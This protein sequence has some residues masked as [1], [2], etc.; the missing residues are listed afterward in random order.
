MGLIEIVLH[1]KTLIDSVTGP[2]LSTALTFTLYIV[3][4]I[5]RNPEFFKSFTASG[6]MSFYLL[7]FLINI[8]NIIYIFS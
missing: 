1:V 8:R 3:W 6:K 2:A 7:C 4:I 5:L